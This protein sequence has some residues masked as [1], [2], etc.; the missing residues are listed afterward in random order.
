[1]KAAAGALIILFTGLAYL[2]QL[3]KSPT[4]DEDGILAFGENVLNLDFA[5]RYAGPMPGA[6]LNALGARLAGGGDA[7]N[8][9][10]L[11]GARAAG[12][13]VGTLGAILVYLWAL[14]MYGPKGGL[15]S[16]G[17]FCLSPTLIAH[18]RLVGSD[19]PAAIGLTAVIYLFRR[20]LLRGGWGRVAACALAAGACQLAKYSC[21]LIYPLLLALFVLR[22]PAG[23]GKDWCLRGGILRLVGIGLCFALA[24][25]LLINLGFGARGSTLEGFLLPQPYLQ[26]IEMLR[27]KEASGSG[28]GYMYLMGELRKTEGFREYY[29]WA[30]LFKVPLPA[31]F[32]L[33]LALGCTLTNRSG[34]SENGLFTLVP[35]LLLLLYFSFLVKVNLG[36]RYILPA[37]PLLC[38]Y[39]GNFL[40]RPTRGRTWTA[41]ILLAV[42]AASVLSW[43]PHY[44]SYFNEMLLE[45][46]DAYLILADSNLDWGQ[47]D[48]FLADYLRRHPGAA[49]NPA[50]P[51]SGTVIVS[52]NELV[53]VWGPERFRWLREN[54]RPVGH[55]AYSWLIFEVSSEELSELGLEERR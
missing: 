47:N 14:E 23:R 27:A 45:R 42:Q 51:R 2:S 54:F 19:I 7:L 40:Q 3:N 21:L 50:G 34:F 22:I 36:I 4:Y 31:L 38:L 35:A 18:S 46:T 8:P 52:A 37:F 16:L 41:G 10:A 12:I 20:M 13:L 30:L 15:L 25:L 43:H 55:V 1:M 53:G 5:R 39:A 33:G 49:V 24:G 17:L 26:G 48:H 6:A 11:A 29:F 32:L 28:F 9:R 44:L